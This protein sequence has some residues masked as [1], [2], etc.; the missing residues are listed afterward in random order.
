LTPLAVA[1]IMVEFVDLVFAVDSVPAVFAVT[2]DTF[3]VYTS[4]IFAILGLRS[5][6]FLIAGVV[7][8]FRYLSVGLAMVL[9]FIGAKMLMTFFHLEIP[10]AVSLAVV[11]VVLAGS[12]VASLV[13]R[14][15]EE[16]EGDEV[17]G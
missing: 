1:L 13:A 9:V 12:I 14:N 6:Y 11:A 7:G 3:I 10:I 17:N 16:K 15:R 8:R 5:M 4:N 2:Q